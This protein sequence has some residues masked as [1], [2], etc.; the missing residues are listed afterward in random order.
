MA[1]D[2]GVKIDITTGRGNDTAQVPHNRQEN[3]GH[4]LKTPKNRKYITVT[5][6]ILAAKIVL[7]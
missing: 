5:V 4:A 6:S 7:F 1:V 3:G 2:D